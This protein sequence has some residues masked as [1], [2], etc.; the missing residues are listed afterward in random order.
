MIVESVMSK[1]ISFIFSLALLVGGIATAAGQ[2]RPVPA[3]LFGQLLVESGMEYNPPE[4]FEA[5]PVQA[6]PLL[7][8]ERA[9]R[10]ADGSLE[11]RYALR[12]L[13]RIEVDYEDPH[14]SAPDPN[15]MFPLMFQSLVTSL[16]NGSNS[17]T[18]EYTP[19]QAAEQFNAH[20]AAAAV[21][22]LNPD[23]NS[24][25]RQAFI[26]AMHKNQLA[27]AYTV[28]L[29]DDLEQAKASIKANLSS[30]RFLP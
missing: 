4:G 22:D 21:F 1:S 27:D 16:S 5:V 20:W 25:Y 13:A 6:N 23:F 30:L 3:D 10:G 14:S 24:A 15:H 2:E 9:I 19:A 8:Y 18:R 28:L 17:P 12:P 26:L 7:P 11:I 29:F